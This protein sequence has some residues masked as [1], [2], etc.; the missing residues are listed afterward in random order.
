MY[1]EG[2][3]VADWRHWQS[4]MTSLIGDVG[5]ER[6]NPFNMF[7]YCIFNRQEEN[8]LIKSIVLKNC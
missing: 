7:K 6:V 5:S 1:G 8:I 4:A 3:Q 2:V